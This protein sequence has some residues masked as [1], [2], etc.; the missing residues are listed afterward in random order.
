[1][2][3]MLLLAIADLRALLTTADLAAA[4]SVEGLLGTDRVFAAD[5]QALRPQV[6]QAASAANMRAVLAG[7]PI[8]RLATEG[9]HRV[10]DAY[11]LRC[12]PQV[13]GARA[14]RSSTPRWSP[15]AS[16]PPPSTT[17][18][19][20]STAGSSRT[21]T[22]TARRSPTCSTSW[23]SSR[24]RREHERA[25]H[26][27]VPRRGPQP[28]PAAVPRRRPRRRLGPHDRASTR[29]PR[30]SRAEAARRAGSVDSIPSSAMQEDHVSMGWS[31]ARKLRRSIDGAHPVL[32]IELLTARGRSTCA[33]RCAGAG[34][35]RGGRAAARDGRR[36]RPDR[37]LAPEI[38][39][40]SSSRT[41]RL[42]GAVPPP[43][44]V[45]ASGVPL[46]QERHGVK[47]LDRG[48]PHPS[49]APRGTELT[50]S[51]LAAGGGA[52][53]AA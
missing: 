8:C 11:S 10:Q 23:R 50:R 21:A 52:A 19:S 47:A 46:T 14:T 26:R 22:S 53:D 32:A 25:A 18:W 42:R 4:M 3:G 5:L 12:A 30:S 20:R 33:R 27:P 41:G 28:R 43:S 35:R 1:M 31:A 2:L 6:G 49:R 40:P 37:Y 36:P 39:R 45:R 48:E 16:S 29:R 51:G 17:R 9:L 13:H 38:E 7:S 15:A 44:E 24:R 34:H